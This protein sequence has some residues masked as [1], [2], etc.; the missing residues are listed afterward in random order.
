MR[1]LIAAYCRVFA[2]CGI[3]VTHTHIYIYLTPFGVSETYVE[4]YIV[5]LALNDKNQQN[6]NA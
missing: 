4:Y 1:Y 2:S 6:Y 3:L 5:S